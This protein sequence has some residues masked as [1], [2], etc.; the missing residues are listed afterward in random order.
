ML[1]SYR[2][3]AEQFPPL[4][5]SIRAASILEADKAFNAEN[6]EH[7]KKPVDRFPNIGCQIKT[8]A[9]IRKRLI[10][11]YAQI[12]ALTKP[13]CAKCPTAYGCCDATYCASA[14]QT[15]KDVWDT[16]IEPVGGKIPMLG[17]EGCI[18]PPHMRG[19]CSVH[20]CEIS[21]MGAK[22]GDLA[23]TTQY[24]ILRSEIEELEYEL[25]L[26]RPL[27]IESHSPSSDI[28]LE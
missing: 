10:D 19:I 24:Y 13:E 3:Y 25:S 5:F 16:I 2:D 28:S 20:T 26:F 7:L 6:Q 4:I 22:R 23:W 14:K 12:A 17:P 11:Q 9:D 1:Y 18:V 15:A 21:S 27:F 8:E